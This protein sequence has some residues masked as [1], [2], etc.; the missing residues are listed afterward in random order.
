MSETTRP[1][2]HLALAVEANLTEHYAYLGRAPQAEMADEGDLLWVITGVMSA[3]QNGIVRARLGGLSSAALDTRIETTLRRFR[4]RR[5]YLSWWVGPATTPAD[6]GAHLAA[7]GWRGGDPPG[8]AADLGA[9]R[10]NR[11]TPAGLEVRR[12]EDEATLWQWV[13]ALGEEYSEAD[14]RAHVELYASLGLA[15]DVPWRHYVGL[16]EGRPVAA[17]SVFLG[18]GA[19]GIYNVAVAP[20]LR[21]QGIGSA[22]TLAPLREARATGYQVGVLQSSYLGTFLY[23]HLGFREVGRLGQYCPSAADAS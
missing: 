14:R 10:E 2:N 16:L 11:P 7:R 8:L 17:S 9:L 3:T 18:G 4:A 22:M 15:G 1:D 13:S 19:A 21:R 20:A 5:V 12:V 23:Q 6:L